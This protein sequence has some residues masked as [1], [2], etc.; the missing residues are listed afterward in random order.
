MRKLL[1]LTLTLLSVFSIYAQKNVDIDSQYFSY[2]ERNTPKS[3][4]NPKFFYYATKINLPGSIKN[5]VSE[6]S[7]Y[8]KFKIDGQRIT[9][10]PTANDL[11]VTV[12][13]GQFSI[14]DVNIRER[15]VENKDKDGKVTSRNYYYWVEALYTF[16]SD[17][18]ANKGEQ[19]VAQYNLY[20]S[21]SKMTYNSGEYSSRKDASENWSNNKDNIKEKLIN[22]VATNS[23]NTASSVL[24]ANYGFP[25]KKERDVIKTIDEKKH[26]E[27]EP[28]KAMSNALKA[29]LETL[30]GT[31]PLKEAD[32]SDII[33]YFKAI[34]EKY[35]DPK[36]K[37]DVKL[38]YVANYNL[39]VIY[40]FLDQPD[41]V[42]PFADALIE[43][44]HDKKH[45]EKLNEAAD[46]LALRLNSSDIKTRQFNPDSYFAD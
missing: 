8:S 31:T 7:L 3:P 13:M 45:G 9:D 25:L 22:D 2:V 19:K 14:T 46:K 11:I 4:L 30:D 39:S 42:K 33:E 27:N 15:V 23:I 1:L 24:S 5:Y 43:N 10:N 21:N 36:L 18:L 44:G 16:Q 34:P 17:L 29:K 28:L 20:S 26:P 37:A 6:E 38:R 41:K 35:T 12:T 40:L 32:L